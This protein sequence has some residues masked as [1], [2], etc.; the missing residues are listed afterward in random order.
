MVSVAVVATTREDY[1][2][3]KLFRSVRRS[4]GKQ[5]MCTDHNTQETEHSF[6]QTEGEVGHKPDCIVCVCVSVCMCVQREVRRKNK[7]GQTMHHFCCVYV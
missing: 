6:G 1:F 2:L 5:S 7:T 3:I 4:A